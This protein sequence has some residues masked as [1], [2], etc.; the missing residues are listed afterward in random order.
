MI[1]GK[2]RKYKL[3]KFPESVEKNFKSYCEIADPEAVPRLLQE[4]EDC[5][6]LLQ[7]MAEKNPRV[8]FDVAKRLAEVS[9]ALLRDYQSFG[10]R[11]RGLIIGAVRYFAVLD[12]SV[13]DDGFATGFIDDIQVMNHVL[14]EIGREEMALPVK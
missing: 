10:L 1:F 6:S 8:D 11:E 14:E 2:R 12:D 5:L 4:L 7:Q 9:R 3:P 13:P